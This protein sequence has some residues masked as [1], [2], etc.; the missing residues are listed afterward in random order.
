MNLRKAVNAMDPLYA[1]KGDR[2]C[3]FRIQKNQPEIE[4]EEVPALSNA[5]RGGFGSTGI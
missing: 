3:Q 1:P 4:F 2:I 5:N